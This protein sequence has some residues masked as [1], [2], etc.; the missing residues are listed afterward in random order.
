[1]KLKNNKI[2]LSP[3]HMGKK[4][5]IIVKRAF[6]SNWITTKGP[7]LDSFEKKISNYINIKNVAAVS[8]GTAAIHLALILLGIKKDDIVICQSFTF[9]GTINP[10]MYLGAKP[11]FIDSEVDTWN[12]D[13]ENLKQA[14]KFYLNK[15]KKPKAIIVVHLY[16]MPAKIKEIQ[17]ISKEYNIPI[18][19]DA[20]E[21][22][23]SSY[24]YKKCGS[25]GDL[26][27][28]SFN[29]NKIVTTSGG[30]ALLSNNSSLIN[31]A[32]FLSTQ[33]RDKFLHYQHSHVGYN[34]RMSNIL[35]SIGIA[36]LEIIQD[37]IK[38]RRKNFKIYKE[39]FSNVEGVSLLNEP[40]NKSKKSIYFS[41]KWLTTILLDKKILKKIDRNK[42][43]NI[44]KK[45]NI[46][47]RPLWKPMHLQ[48]IF[49]NYP[50]FGRKVAENLFKNGLC[51]PS[52]SNLSNSDFKR[53]FSCFN[54]VFK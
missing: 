23:G 27:I 42:I 53:I 39:Y 33:A 8:S 6:N 15:G 11:I 13:P 29:G 24:N 28:L 2:Y 52:G 25:F 12:I 51:L 19:E 37:R 31:K 34:Y 36:Q 18:I 40:R 17:R 45:E 4:E 30:G 48:P 21:A 46:E 1:M 5:Q 41:N 43:I 16:G 22:L 49:K 9:V 3:P 32:K 50:Y 20:A 54:K 26:G 10:V 14:I 47:A 35:A 7:Q 38:S 44:L